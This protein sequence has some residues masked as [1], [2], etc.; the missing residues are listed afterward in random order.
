MWRMD[1]VP[2]IFPFY[3][4]TFFAFFKNVKHLY[5]SYI[6]MKNETVINNLG[7]TCISGW[8]NLLQLF[9]NKG[10]VRN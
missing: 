8:R 10:L 4:V 3:Q 6:P 9:C 1:Y 2:V 7:G 5:I